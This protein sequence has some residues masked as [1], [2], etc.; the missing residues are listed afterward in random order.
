[1]PPTIA[2]AALCVFV[3]L[4][5]LFARSAEGRKR[6]IREAELL[7]EISDLRTVITNLSVDVHRAYTHPS[8][9]GIYHPHYNVGTSGRR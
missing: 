4:F 2:I 1:M 9:H 3:F 7:Q 5:L 6:R 8:N